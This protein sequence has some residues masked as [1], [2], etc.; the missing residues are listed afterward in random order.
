MKYELIDKC[1]G[2]LVAVMD[3]MSEAVETQYAFR[4]VH[5]IALAIVE[6]A[7]SRYVFAVDSQTEIS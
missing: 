2:E 7:D 5:N 3:S 4:E 6:S 1:T